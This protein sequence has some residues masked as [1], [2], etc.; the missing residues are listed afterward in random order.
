MRIL[1]F[2]E[3]KRVASIVYAHISFPGGQGLFPFLLE[4]WLPFDIAYQ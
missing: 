4:G 2:S 3:T 1:P